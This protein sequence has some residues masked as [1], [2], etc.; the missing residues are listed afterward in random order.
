[1]E[2]SCIHDGQ[3][4]HALSTRSATCGW[5]D[6]RGRLA[7]CEEI[8]SIPPIRQL[9]DLASPHG[10]PEHAPV[11]VTID[12]PESRDHALR[13]SRSVDR[14]ANLVEVA[15]ETDPDI[16]GTGI[17]P[18]LV[19]PSSSQGIRCW[20]LEKMLRSCP[21]FIEGQRDVGAKSDA[22]ALA[23]QLRLSKGSPRNSSSWSSHWS[24]VSVCLPHRDRRHQGHVGS[25]GS[26]TVGMRGF[27]AVP[28]PAPA[29]CSYP[30]MRALTRSW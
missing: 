6:C 3:W 18:S 25:A 27:P 28:W 20:L 17:A 10:R 19:R 15:S 4:R 23:L 12:V 7:Y 13:V 29:P 9:F 8:R 22:E 16:G 14:T 26:L 24:L 5:A 21:S 1:M 30:R 11:L 2:N